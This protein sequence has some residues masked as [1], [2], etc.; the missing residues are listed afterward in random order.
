MRL[1]VH[2]L[3]LSELGKTNPH[4]VPT[5]TVHQLTLSELGRG[6]VGELLPVRQRH[7]RQGAA[8]GLEGRVVLV[9]ERPAHTYKHMFARVC[10]CMRLYVL[11]MV[12]VGKRRGG[13]GLC[14][15]LRKALQVLTKDS[16]MCKRSSV[17]RG[18]E[19]SSGEFLSTRCA[20]ST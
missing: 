7:T 16:V 1:T 14:H 18:W 10:V 3:T 6:L 17:L 19:G 11:V 2:Q 8:E 20:R 12:M 4:C 15:V 9:R 13:R 5:L